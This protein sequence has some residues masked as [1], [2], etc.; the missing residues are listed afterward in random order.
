MFLKTILA[1]I[2]FPIIILLGMVCG[3]AYFLTVWINAVW[4]YIV[5]AE[6]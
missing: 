6:G 5:E 3:I 1:V 2:A 4:K